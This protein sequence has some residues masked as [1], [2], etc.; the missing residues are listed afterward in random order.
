[1]PLK[2]FSPSRVLLRLPDP[3]PDLVSSGLP[4]ACTKRECSLCLLPRLP[5]GM[6]HSSAPE[7]YRDWRWGIGA[8]GWISVSKLGWGW[9]KARVPKMDSFQ[10]CYLSSPDQLPSCGSPPIL[11]P[12]YL[13]RWCTRPEE[14][15]LDGAF[16]LHTVLASPS[17]K[18]LEGL[19]RW[20]KGRDKCL[21]RIV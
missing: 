7:N 9:G 3:D 18:P 5:A 17:S 8:E 10:H 20:G 19:G 16:I 11:P 6:Y 15:V 21:E 4:A 12:L 2:N 13:I 1:M 14:P